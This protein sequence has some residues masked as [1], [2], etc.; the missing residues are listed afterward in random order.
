M[1]SGGE[2][3]SQSGGGSQRR[4]GA[5]RGVRGITHSVLRIGAGLL[6]FMHGAPKLAGWGAGPYSLDAWRGRK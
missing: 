1:E 3:Q 4:A 6:F 5:E 2:E